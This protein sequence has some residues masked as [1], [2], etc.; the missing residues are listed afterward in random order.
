MR[1]NNALNFY[2]KLQTRLFDEIR[3]EKVN[4]KV[5]HLKKSDLNFVTYRIELETSRFMFYKKY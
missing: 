5:S 2:F 3:M 1:K 4:A